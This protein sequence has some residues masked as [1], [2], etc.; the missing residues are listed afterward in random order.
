[1]VYNF[2]LLVPVDGSEYGLPTDRRQIRA[3]SPLDLTQTLLSSH[4]QL[5]I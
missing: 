3:L 4:N 5:Q 1:M 2:Q